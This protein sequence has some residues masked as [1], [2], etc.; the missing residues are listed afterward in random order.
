MQERVRQGHLSRS[1][2]VAEFT[3]YVGKNEAA[4]GCPLQMMN[5]LRPHTQVESH[6]ARCNAIAP[7]IETT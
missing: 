6:S 3:S 2:N 7:L 5:R 1:G 4:H